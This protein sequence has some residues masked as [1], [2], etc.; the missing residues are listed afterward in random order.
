M[1]YMR[2]EFPRYISDFKALEA[3]APAKDRAILKRMTEHEVAAI[4]FL[5]QEAA[6]DPNSTAPLNA[7]LADPATTAKA[8]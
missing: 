2:A 8:A 6:G 4:A 5:E 3:M 1:T 7:F